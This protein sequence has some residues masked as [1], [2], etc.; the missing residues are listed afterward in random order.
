MARTK[1]V[2][3]SAERPPNSRSDS[4]PTGS[5]KRP[6]TDDSDSEWDGAD[7]VADDEDT[8]ESKPHAPVTPARTRDEEFWFEDGS[9]ILVAGDV[10]FRVF[11]S[12]LAQYSP[13]FSDMFSLPQPSFTSGSP[14]D[15]CPVVHLSDSPEDLRHILRVSMPK[16]STR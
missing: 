2:A 10:E 7:C 3:R 1:Q 6:R 4:L 12:I 8:T 14:A 15:P 11:R 13:V 5:N 16:S 9:V